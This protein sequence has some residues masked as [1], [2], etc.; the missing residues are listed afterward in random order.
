MTPHDGNLTVRAPG[1]GPFS[2]TSTVDCA[3]SAGFHDVAARLKDTPA[4]IAKVFPAGAVRSITSGASMRATI[5]R[6]KGRVK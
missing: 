5:C 4:R 1:Q 6:N 3:S 2:R